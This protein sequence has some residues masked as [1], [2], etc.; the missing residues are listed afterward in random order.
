VRLCRWV[1]E[2]PGLISRPVRKLISAVV[3]G[4]SSSGSLQQSQIVRALQEPGRL[5]HTQKRLSRG[6]RSF[7]TVID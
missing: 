2:L 3:F 1:D 6:N 7:L 4:I 5:H